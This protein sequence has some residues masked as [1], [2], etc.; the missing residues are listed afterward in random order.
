MFRRLKRFVNDTGPPNPNT[1][2]APNAPPNPE[3]T[4]GH[5]GVT[6][7]APRGDFTEADLRALDAVGAW[8]PRNGGR[9]D[10][11]S[12]VPYWSDPAW[13]PDIEVKLD[14]T[15]Q[16]ARL[17]GDGVA[18]GMRPALRDEELR[19]RNPTE[20]AKY[21]V[22][23]CLTVLCFLVYQ[24]DA[25]QL[26][27]RVRS[28]LA[29][30]ELHRRFGIWPGP[31]RDGEGHSKMT[32]TKLYY[33]ALPNVQRRD[34]EDLDAD[35]SLQAFI[36]SGFD[37]S[38]LLQTGAF[39]PTIDVPWPPDLDCELHPLLRFEM[40]DQRQMFMPSRWDGA[41]DVRY[42]PGVWGPGGSFD[43]V[44]RVCALRF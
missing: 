42:G 44:G 17:A 1:G 21:V 5:A 13:R 4:G 28:W 37:T 38:E 22:G 35:D 11:F 30:R 34:A 18:A 27:K 2:A 3:M 9:P 14:G 10:R 7:G 36:F 33:D 23:R 12:Y 41:L 39:D 25:G 24:G 20:Y 26:R 19:L 31:Q 6:A 8:V 40:W 32:P 29:D 43:V 16:R 15:E